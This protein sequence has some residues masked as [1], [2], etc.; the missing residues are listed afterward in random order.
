MAYSPAMSRIG[1]RLASGWPGLLAWWSL[2]V[3]P[4][5]CI[6]SAPSESLALDQLA[7]A[8]RVSA[9]LARTPRG[10]RLGI[11]DRTTLCFDR[12]GIRALELDVE[13][14]GSL[15]VLWAAYQGG[16]VSAI[17]RRRLPEGPSRLRIDLSQSKGWTPESRPALLVDGTGKLVLTAARVER[18]PEDP[19]AFRALSD[20][21]LFLGPENIGH[22]TIHFFQAPWWRASRGSWLPDRL[23]GLALVLVGLVLLRDRFRRRRPRL[24]LALALGALFAAGGYDTYFLAR[25]LPRYHLRPEFDP[26]TRIRENYSFEPEVGAL[27]ALAREVLGPQERVGVLGEPGDWFGPQTICFNLAPREC[28]MVRTDRLEQTGISGVGRLRLEDLD[29]LVVLNAEAA[30]P[31]GFR[32]VARIDA[33]SFVARRQ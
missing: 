22:T 7:T 31:A 15:Q 27:A 30:L 16:P 24:G 33:G 1:A 19:E 29:A 28:V 9:P 23:A 17:G 26:E 3:V 25:F 6:P 5:G 21:A 32:P 14:T 10:L 13:A 2:A 11:E 8:L 18:A 12:P 20:R 4:A